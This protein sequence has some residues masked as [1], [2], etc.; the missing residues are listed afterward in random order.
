MALT[1]LSAITDGWHHSGLV[2]VEVCDAPTLVATVEVRPTL[3]C[4]VPPIVGGPAG[5]PVTLS[6]VELKPEM[7]GAKSPDQTTGSSEPTI[8][9]AE[10]L[11]PTIRRAEEEE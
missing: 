8:L 7:R 10:D 2:E 5:A 4:T 3:R 9:S 6:G 11:A 1:A